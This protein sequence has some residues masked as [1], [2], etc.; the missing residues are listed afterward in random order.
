MVTLR[1][2]GQ[3]EEEKENEA[4][5]GVLHFANI[6]HFCVSPLNGHTLDPTAKSQTASPTICQNSELPAASSAAVA[7]MAWVNWT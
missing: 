4:S 3:P 1:M 5:V 2:G 6:F 7:L